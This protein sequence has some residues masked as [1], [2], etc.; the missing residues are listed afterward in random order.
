MQI[1]RVKEFVTAEIDD[2]WRLSPPSEKSFT[3]AAALLHREAHLAEIFS[4]AQS[5]ASRRAVHACMAND[6]VAMHHKAG[7]HCGAAPCC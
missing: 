5:T 6:E 3:G 1:R 2:C 4:T 7:R